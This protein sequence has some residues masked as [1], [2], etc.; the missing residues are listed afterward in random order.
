MELKSMKVSKAEKKEHMDAMCK[1]MDNEYPYGLRINLEE[2][3][4]SKMGISL[5]AVGSKMKLEAV[6]EVCNVSMYEGEGN[7]KR[8]SMSL[9]ITEM[10]LEKSASSDAAK[11]LYGA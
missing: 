11:K 2:D 9:Q 1:P 4:I 10:G 6:V 8:R 3:A 5:P 7:H